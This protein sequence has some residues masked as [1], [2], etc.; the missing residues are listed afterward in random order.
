MARKKASSLRDLALS[1]PVAEKKRTWLHRIEKENPAIAAEIYGIMLDFT[2]HDEE[3]R[4]R[5]PSQHA[6][7]AFL[8]TVPEIEATG[9]AESGVV[10]LISKIANGRF[11][12]E[13]KK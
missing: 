8:V 11:R 3:L 4:A 9:V 5:F 7:A 2:K 12:Y 13:P 6:L 10:D 1:L